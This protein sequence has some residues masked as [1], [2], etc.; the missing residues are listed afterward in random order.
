MAIQK[1]EKAPEF[2][3]FDSEKNKISLN[4]YAGKKNVLLLFFPLAFT[5]VCTKELCAVRDDIGKYD[6]ENTALLCISVDSV[7]ALMKF[8]EEQQY[9]YPLLSDFNKEASIAYDCLYPSFGDLEMIG[10]S[11]RSAF[12]IDKN[13]IIQ[14][15][16]VL[17]S[18]RDMPDFSAIDGK[19]AELS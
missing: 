3:L 15:S 10:V 8:K 11:K 16:E 6:N 7:Y 9:T 13:G 12:I 19:L 5:R 18:A 14:Y 4:D 17:E 1:G 2:T